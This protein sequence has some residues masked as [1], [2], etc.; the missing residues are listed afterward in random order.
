MRVYLAGRYQERDKLKAYAEQLRGAGIVCTS[1]WLDETLQPDTQLHEVSDEE[2]IGYAIWD[3]QDVDEADFLVQ[4]C[5]VPNTRGGAHV[6][7]GY[8]LKGGKQIVVVG[9]EHNIFHKLPSVLKTDTWE[10]ALTYLKEEK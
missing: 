10:D 5:D 1:R 4:I 6:E 7:F 2:L 8:A 3:L 9:P